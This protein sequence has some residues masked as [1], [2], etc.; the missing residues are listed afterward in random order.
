M[1]E[2]L[3]GAPAAPTPSKPTTLRGRLWN[4]AP[5][6]LFAVYVGLDLYFGHTRPATPGPIFDTK[7]RG[8]DVF[9]VTSGE[10]LLLHIVQ[11]LAAVLMIAWILAGFPATKRAVAG[12]GEDGS[13]Q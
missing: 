10:A 1:S 4:W 7:Y 6:T 11:G 2:S 9:Y 13:G 5:F 12:E 8:F 3:S